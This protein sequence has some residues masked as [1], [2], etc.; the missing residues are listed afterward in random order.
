MRHSFNTSANDEM[1]MDNGVL[2]NEL[3]K[4]LSFGWTGQTRMLCIVKKYNYLLNR[5][6]RCE[7]SMYLNV[8]EKPQPQLIAAYS[9]SMYK[10]MQKYLTRRPPSTTN[11]TTTTTRITTAHLST[12]ILAITTLEN[13]VSLK[14]FFSES[15]RN[16]ILQPII[17]LISFIIFFIIV[18]L[19]AFYITYCNRHPNTS[20]D[21][22]QKIT[23]NGLFFTNK[24]S[25][26][27]Q[28]NSTATSSNHV[29]NENEELRP[30]KCDTLDSITSRCSRFIDEKEKSNN[31]QQQQDYDEDSL[32]FI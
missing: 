20:S 8:K 28:E 22:I 1:Q 15:K 23:P 27:S 9:P 31:N 14:P 30:S 11:A 4:Q 13:T 29:M 7:Q 16:P 10:F 19:F 25:P 2:I 18:I 12:I 6:T 24:F 26:V 17:I 21:I 5:F 32:N 3:S